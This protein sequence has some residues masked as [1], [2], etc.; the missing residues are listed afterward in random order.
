M[1]WDLPALSLPFA[2]VPIPR[3]GICY[4]HNLTST[5]I[6]YPHITTGICIAISP[7]LQEVKRVP[8]ALLNAAHRAQYDHES[9][10]P[11]LPLFSCSPS[12]LRLYVDLFDG[13]RA[14]LALTPSLY[15]N[16]TLLRESVRGIGGI[17][18]HFV[19]ISGRYRWR[20]TSFHPTPHPT[21]HPASASST[22]VSVIGRSSRQIEVYE[23]LFP[24]CLAAGGYRITVSS[25]RTLC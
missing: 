23:G 24:G 25:M 15:N 1:S 20:C 2:S 12:G 19:P 18:P 22:G 8:Y 7:C 9:L 17:P 21:S 16:D 10:T 3:S 13:G 6:W 4:L 11:P 14:I 5:G